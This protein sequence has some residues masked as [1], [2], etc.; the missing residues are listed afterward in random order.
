[1]KVTATNT[2][3]N[4]KSY[5]FQSHS[6]SKNNKS[7]LNFDKYSFVTKS[8]VFSVIYFVFILLFITISGIIGLM[9]SF[10]LQKYNLTSGILKWQLWHKIFFFGGF[11]FLTS[12]FCLFEAESIVEKIIFR[13]KIN[14]D[15]DNDKDL[16][17]ILKIRPN[18]WQKIFYA[19]FLFG[20]TTLIAYLFLVNYISWN[21][22]QFWE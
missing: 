21:Y 19:V 7:S 6:N 17:S 16:K 2:K 11:L 14:N 3:E 8:L 4:S 20:F 18:R 12:N 22:T 1:M 10:F 15:N 9:L 5:N 13:N